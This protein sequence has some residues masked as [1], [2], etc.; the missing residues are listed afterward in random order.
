MKQYSEPARLP[1]LLGE[2]VSNV[3][4]TTAL[5]SLGKFLFWSLA[6]GIAYTQAPLYTS[7]QNT[8][9][10][11]GLADGGLG[12]LNEDWLA[13]TLDPFPLFSFLVY[14]TYRYFHANAFY[15]YNIVIFGVYL[16]SVAGIVA[17]ICNIKE[18]GPK[19]VTF[20]VATIAIHSYALDSLSL[21]ISGFE[22]AQLHYGFAEYHIIGRIFQPSVFGV[23][24]LLS[25]YAFLCR[26]RFLAAFLLVFSAV[27]HPTYLLSSGVMTL[28]YMA[29]VYREETNAKKAL[30]LGIFNLILILPLLS[31]LYIYFS[32]TSPELW[33]KSKAV[34]VAVRSPHHFNP[35]VWLGGL[36]YLKLAMMA[37]AIYLARNTRL[38]LIMLLP[39]SI[40][41][42]LTVAQVLWGNNSLAILTPWRMFIFLVPLSLCIIVGHL[43]SRFFDMF[44]EPVAQRHKVIMVA[45]L[46]VLLA[47]VAYGANTQVKRLKIYYEGESKPMMNFVREAK[48]AGDQFL[49]PVELEDFRLYTGAPI[50]VNF[51]SGP[52]KDTEYMQWYQR[53]V[54]ATDFY[55]ARDESACHVLRSL[56]DQYK[57]THVVVEGTHPGGRCGNL[58]ELYKDDYYRV[59]RLEKENPAP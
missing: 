19:Y 33:S 39:F 15:F 40:A 11:I 35:E 13:N 1:L 32:P 30:S 58:S 38:F 16:Y 44:I 52:Y 21:R 20:L 45:N 18:S 3:V 49:V 37:A 25:I 7:N 24:L 34:L 53:F 41:T 28:T 48:S 46:A 22:L 29:V 36:V 31:F 59:Y 54:G 55:S 9:F 2:R 57:L 17:K 4:A 42:I 47:L 10:L 51:K 8:K 56:R 6:F 14:A 26:R 23:F 43:T 27:M 5:V 50:L 12:F